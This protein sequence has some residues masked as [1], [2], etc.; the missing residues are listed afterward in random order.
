MI[1]YHS[2]TLSWSPVG[3]ISCTTCDTTIAKPLV[4][5]SYFGTATNAFNCS[6]QDSNYI[7]IIDVPFTT[8]ILPESVKL[9]QFET[10][11]VD[12][13]PKGKKILWTPSTG[14]SDATSYNPVIAP[15]Q[16]TVYTVTLTDSTGCTTAGSSA[17]V[18]VFVNPA[19]TVNAGPDRFYPKG[20]T[21]TIAP[22]YS[23]NIAT[24][25]WTPS[26]LLTCNNCATPSG[27]NEYT[28]QYIIKVT[29]DS[30][31]VASDTITISL[32]CKSANIFIPKAFTPNNDNLNDYFYPSGVGVKSI[33][34][35]TIYN[36]QGRVLFE[37]SNFKPNDKLYGWNGKYKG[38]NQS[39]DTY[40]YS[41]EAICEFGETLYKKGS[42][43]L[44][45]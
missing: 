6:V 35:F 43:L 30:G 10:A 13:N 42:F 24:Y 38:A 20:S 5:T 34:K 9:C 36:R 7:K 32:E 33:V 14:L 15:L 21:Y 41:L 27:I 44:L 2:N 18:S 11:M 17:T 45:K 28:Q 4:S 37:A 12:V 26:V 1:A 25:F 3:N 16:N 22:T 31:C 8:S 19:L 39:V 29:S 40:V 23:G